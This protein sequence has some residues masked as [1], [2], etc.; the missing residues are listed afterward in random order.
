M[1]DAGKEPSAE[2]KPKVKHKET[3]RRQKGAAEKTAQYIIKL[4]SQPFFVFC[5]EAAKVGLL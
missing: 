5:K 1:K 4:K 3:E 2:K